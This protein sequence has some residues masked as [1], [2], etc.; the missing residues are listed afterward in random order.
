MGARDGRRHLL[1]VIGGTAFTVWNQS[2]VNEKVYTVAL[3]GLAVVSWLML[4]WSDAP[5]RA[6]SDRFLLTAAYLVGLGYANHPAGFLPLPA[7]GLLVLMRQPSALLRWRLLLGTLAVAIVGLT[8]FVAM[9][10]RAA[11]EPYLNSGA[12]SACTDGIAV[13]CTFSAETWR[14]LKSHID[15]EQ[16]SGHNVAERKAPLTAQY[17]MFWLYFKWQWFRDAF[18]QAPGAQSLLACALLR[19]RHRRRRGALQAGPTNI[20]VRGRPRVHAHGRAGGVP[21]LQVRPLA[22]AGARQQR[23]PRG[24]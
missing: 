21:Q 1:R 15:R 14:R 20:L 4:R 7:I 17:G 8:P 10:I 9:P 13:S 11:Y 19:A 12:T 6:S 16:Y 18:N 5:E 22:G 23:G 24:A 2:V 3:L